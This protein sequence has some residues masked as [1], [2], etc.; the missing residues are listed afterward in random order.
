MAECADEVFIQLVHHL[1]GLGEITFEHLFVDGTKMEANTNKYSFVW[2][3]S[4]N[5]HE[6]RLDAKLEKL[7][8][9]LCGKYGVVAADPN[10]LLSA[11]EDKADFPF[12]HGRG[13]RKSALQQDIEQLWELLSRKQK[14]EGYNETFRGRNIFSK[15]GPDAA[16]LA[17]FHGFGTVVRRGDPWGLCWL[18]VKEMEAFIPV[19]LSS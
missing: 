2:K 4:T 12:V 11:L 8:P 9:E 16:A 1:H 15:T 3:K 17:V 10:T 14:Y 7:L 18:T 6:A 13:K 5:K 19:P